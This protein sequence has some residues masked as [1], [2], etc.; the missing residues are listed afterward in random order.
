MVT[1]KFIIMKKILRNIAILL[2]VCSLLVFSACEDKIPP[3]I[4][5]LDFSRAFTPVELTA[6]ISNV[7]TVTLN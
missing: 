2:G 3:V 5:E 1:D 7:T 4:E 6:Q